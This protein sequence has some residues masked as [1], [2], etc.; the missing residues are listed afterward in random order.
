[1]TLSDM[2]PATRSAGR[3]QLLC[4][5]QQRRDRAGAPPPLRIGS[6]TC[7]TS[8]VLLYIKLDLELTRRLAVAG[9][10]AAAN[11]TATAPDCFAIVQ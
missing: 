1:M 2:E 3:A 11:S 8:L 9:C 10:C 4:G 6:D 7:E 5:C